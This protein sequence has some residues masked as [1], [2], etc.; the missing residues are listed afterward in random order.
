VVEA[1]KIELAQGGTKD[2]RIEIVGGL[3]PLPGTN[4]DMSRE[5]ALKAAAFPAVV[6]GDKVASARSCR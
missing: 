1:A 5:P 2:Q 4:I 6:N 3:P